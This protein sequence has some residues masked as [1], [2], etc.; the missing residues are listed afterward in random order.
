MR[1]LRCSRPSR[2]RPRPA[3]AAQGAAIPPS[4]AQVSSRCPIRASAPPSTCGRWRGCAAT[5]RRLNLSSRAENRGIAVKPAFDS[6]TR[7][8]DSASDGRVFLSNRAISGKRR[9][10]PDSRLGEL[11]KRSPL[12]S[13]FAALANSR[14]ASAAVALILWPVGRWP[15][16]HQR[17]R[18]AAPSRFRPV[19]D[20]SAGRGS[21]PFA[22]GV[23]ATSRQGT[24]GRPA[25]PG[26]TGP[27]RISLGT[28]W[29]GCSC[30]AQRSGGSSPKRTGV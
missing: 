24:G 13:I 19:A 5:A 17:Q 27:P 25:R 12:A 23:I 16:R 9:Q 8:T 18:K 1:T 20:R 26:P 4:P 30:P 6:D 2:R 14:V 11:R 3:L 28:R 22:R 21:R 7:P 10:G 15:A 29:S